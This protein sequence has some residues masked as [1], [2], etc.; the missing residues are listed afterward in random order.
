MVLIM[1]VLFSIVEIFII[2]Q[3]IIQKNPGR[4]TENII[5]A[6]VAILFV[7]F[8]GN[9]GIQM[10]DFITAFWLV[11]I[12]GHTFISEYCKVYRKSKTYDRYLHLFGS[13]TF[14]LFT[15]SIISSLMKPVPSKGY[16]A[17]LIAMLGI[18]VGD[19]FEIAEFTLD[20][21]LKKAK[22]QKS[23][24]AWQTPVMT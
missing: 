22:Y 6:V 17:V 5:V 23:Q 20:T 24:H 18:S 2:S 13:F 11:T 12:L 16:V 4:L 3:Y 8:K 7:L 9:L 10:Y 21:V 1:M 14:S 15:Y 19:F